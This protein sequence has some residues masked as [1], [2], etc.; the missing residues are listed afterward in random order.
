MFD[1]A[2]GLSQSWSMNEIH[3]LATDKSKLIRSPLSEGQDPYS[4]V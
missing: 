2:L 3:I 4:V 1:V